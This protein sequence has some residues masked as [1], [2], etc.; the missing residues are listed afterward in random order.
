MRRSEKQV[1]EFRLSEVL[2]NFESQKDKNDKINFIKNQF[3]EIDLKT[4]L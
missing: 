4:L 3:E 1:I 2:I